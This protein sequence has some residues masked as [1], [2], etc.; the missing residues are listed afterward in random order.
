MLKIFFILFI[1]NSILLAYI[2]EVSK[3]KKTIYIQGELSAG[4]SKKLSTAIKQNQDVDTILFTSEG[5]LVNEGFEL[6]HLIQ[7]Y[8]LN[9]AVLGE[10]SSSCVLAFMGGNQRNLINNAKI[11]VHSSYNIQKKDIKIE[12]DT[13]ST[14][15]YLSKGVPRGFIRNKVFGTPHNKVYYPTKQELLDN[16]IITEYKK[17]DSKNL[18]WLSNLIDWA[19]NNNLP[20]YEY[21]GTRNVGFPRNPEKLLNLEELNLNVSKNKLTTLPE[22]FAYLTKLR[23]LSLS[24]NKF[25]EIPPIIFEMRNLKALLLSVNKINYVSPKIKNLKN[26]EELSLSFNYIKTIPNEISQ[27]KKLTNLDLRDNFINEKVFQTIKNMPNLYA[28]NLANNNV[29][30]LDIKS[31]QSNNKLKILSLYGTYIT[32]KPTLKNI[33]ILLDEDE[34][35]EQSTYNTLN[36]FYNYQ[37]KMNYQ[38]K[39]RE[40]LWTKLCAQEGNSKCQ[41]NLGVM[42][43]DKF[44]KFDDEQYDKESLIWLQKAASQ[45]NIAAKELLKTYNN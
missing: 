18:I 42:L 9:T 14:S 8:Q 32:S 37:I 21:K 19:N 6:N 15:I 33:K 26:L 29:K 22:E 44:I 7:K 31:I 24:G 38:D 20:K 16:N 11:G 10:C 13:R 25:T 23:V 2:I 41:Y 1:S 40:F 17:L 5:G 3:D 36:D 4:V 34:Y 30:V 39:E 27:L 45:N 43:L 12:D 35:G 28:I